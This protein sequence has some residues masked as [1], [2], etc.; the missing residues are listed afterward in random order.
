MGFGAAALGFL[1][2]QRIVARENPGEPFDSIR[3]RNAV[4]PYIGSGK[5]PRALKR[6]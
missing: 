6:R 5:A 2:V 3:N 4:D 1:S